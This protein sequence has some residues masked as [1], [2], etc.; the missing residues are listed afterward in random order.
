M[1]PG[2]PPLQSIRFLGPL[3]E[4]IQY[5]HYSLATEKVYLYWLC[6]FIRWSARN[7]QI[8]YGHG[9]RTAGD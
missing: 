2:N 3:R 8:Q 1:K 7:G 4:R 6:F 5:M 9:A